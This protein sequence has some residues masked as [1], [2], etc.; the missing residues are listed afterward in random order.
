MQIQVGDSAPN[1]QL[2]DMH[3]TSVQL[4]DLWQPHG[5]IISFL[6]HFG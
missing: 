6:R 2:I 3:G 5:L 1:V 4:A